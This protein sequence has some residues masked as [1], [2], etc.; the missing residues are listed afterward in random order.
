MSTQ[1]ARRKFAFATV[2]AVVFMGSTFGLFATGVASATGPT[3]TVPWP[4]GN[5][6]DGQ[7]VTVSGSGFPTRSQD[8]PGVEIIQCSDPTGTW[9]TSQLTPPSSAM[10]PR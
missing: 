9:R 2:G 4:P 10:G 6:T 3:V 8:P 1:T 7:T 5:P